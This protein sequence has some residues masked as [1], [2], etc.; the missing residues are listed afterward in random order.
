MT[1]NPTGLDVF[2]QPEKPGLVFDLDERS[3]HLGRNSLSASSA[4]VL[5]GKRPPTSQEALSFG[6][7]AHAVLLEPEK[8]QRAYA[9]LDPNEIGV[10]ADGSPA[11]NPTA[12][13]AWKSAVSAAEKAGQLVVTPGQWKR[14]NEMASAV[15]SH[16][17]AA[18]ILAACPQREVSAYAEFAPDVL[19]RGRFDLLGDGM[20][21]DYKTAQDGDPVPFERIAYKFGYHIQAAVYEDL[22]RLNGIENDG[23]RF[24]LCE[25]EQTPGGNYRVSVT[26]LDDLYIEK[27]R[28]EFREAIRRWLALGKV[29]DLPNYPDDEV[30]VGMPSYLHDE[31]EMVVA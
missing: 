18:E 28:Q 17:R 12:T 26:R 3:Y 5:L 13:S 9:V 31:M 10:K 7:L 6:T 14:A 4:K 25:K 27:G 21:A 23:L 24:I 30:I 16:K 8:A 15:F 11:A 19:V 20:I 29:V 1:I 2:A 22:A